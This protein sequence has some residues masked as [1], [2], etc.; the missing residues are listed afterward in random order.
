MLGVPVPLAVLAPVLNP[1]IAAATAPVGDL[2]AT[3]GDTVITPLTD[4]L[5]QLVS[6]QVNVQ[7][8]TAGTFTERALQ[9]GVLPGT[10]LATVQLASSS[11]GP[12][13]GPFVVP[14]AVSLAPPSGPV[15]GGTT[16]TV[17][18]S[19]FVPGATSV[20]IG[21][22]TVAADQVSV[23]A[24]GTSL[25]FSTPP[26]PAGPVDVTVTTR[27]GT[28]A[29]LPFRYDDTT[30]PQPPVIT[31]PPDGF[32]TTEQQPATSGTG[33]PGSTV[34]V[35]EN[36]ILVCTAMV[37]AHG[38]WRCVPVSPLAIGVHTVTAT[39]QDPAGNTSAASA[40]VRF[41]IAAVTSTATRGLAYT[42]FDPS[43]L[44]TLASLLVLAGALILRRFRASI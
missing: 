24:D 17:T 4:A 44:P 31:G 37:D 30:P 42:G 32:T 1:V 28:T 9:L 34:T 35:T 38:A 18:G 41:T 22:I 15:A 33:E 21:G 8:T 40:P 43:S 6:L 2:I 14:T 16:V 26:H 12:N 39:Q 23:V 5:S 10:S 25:S 3:L 29:S 36:G 13:A 11:V 7:E 27:G 19:G 20:T